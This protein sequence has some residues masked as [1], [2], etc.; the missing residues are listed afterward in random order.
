MTR[1]RRASVIVT[2]S[3]LACAATASAECAW[4]VWARPCT[5]GG[6]KTVNA[7]VQRTDRPDV[8][9]T[10]E[11]TSASA[12]GDSRRS[13]VV[14]S[15]RRPWSIRVAQWRRAQW[16]PAHPPFRT[17]RRRQWNRPHARSALR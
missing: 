16:R 5:T 15:D 9:A 17:G 12:Y 8:V 7:R 2:L 11:R 14:S 3:L 13:L 4:E 6:G 10:V 1:L